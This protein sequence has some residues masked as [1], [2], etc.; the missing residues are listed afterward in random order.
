MGFDGIANPHGGNFGCTTVSVELILLGLDLRTVAL[1]GAV[2]LFRSP[3]SHTTAQPP[4]T[5]A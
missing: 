1:L 4:V 5:N 2:L 3:R